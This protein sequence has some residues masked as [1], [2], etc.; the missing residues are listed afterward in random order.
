MSSR[1]RYSHRDP[2][3]HRVE[4]KSMLGDFSKSCKGKEPEMARGH[5]PLRD[6]RDRSLSRSQRLWENWKAFSR[7]YSGEYRNSVYNGR[8]HSPLRDPHDPSLSR[9]QRLWENYK[10]FSRDY[11][12]EYTNGVYTG[13]KDTST[14]PPRPQ[15]R[16]RTRVRDMP[17]PSYPSSSNANPFQPTHPVGRPMGQPREFSP[18]PR[19]PYA[20][21]S[22]SR[23]YSRSSS[24]ATSRGCSR[25]PSMSPSRGQSRSASFDLSLGYSR[26]PPL[27]RTHSTD[28]SSR[29][30]SR[31]SS[32]HP[33]RHRAPSP[34][35][36]RELSHGRSCAPQ[37]R[38]CSPDNFRDYYFP[39]VRG[40]SRGPASG[41]GFDNPHVVN[42][43]NTSDS[44]PFARLPLHRQNPGYTYGSGDY[45][46]VNALHPSDLHRSR[47]QSAAPMPSRSRSRPAT[48]GPIPSM[49]PFS[50]MP[51]MPSRSRS[52]DPIP[53]TGPFSSQ[54][55]SPGMPHMPGR[56]RS[57]PPMQP[58]RFGGPYPFGP[59]PFPPST[60]HGSRGFESITYIRRRIR[61]RHVTYR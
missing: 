35:A 48:R 20:P 7:D 2:S 43:T 57:R 44:N 12:D 18:Y 8:D 37:S 27:S 45:N 26:R 19:P 5:S 14:L 60:P 29:P 23:T 38:G 16:G 22:P 10:A 15:S 40:R 9:S 54:P 3:R 30:S 4:N 41:H 34:F 51:P 49:G 56:S 50:G 1:H 24:L 17:M 13:P 52:C 25:G 61:S 55:L 28:P 46:V 47:S 31:S 6:P 32:R 21:R 42:V 53:N 33:T 36:S 58:F 59:P 11:S 39:N